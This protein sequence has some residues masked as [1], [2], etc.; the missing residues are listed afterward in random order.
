[1]KSSQIPSKSQVEEQQKWKGQK[2]RLYIWPREERGDQHCDE[3]DDVEIDRRQIE[4]QLALAER[5]LATNTDKK[6]G[7]KKSRRSVR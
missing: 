7:K 1:M 5:L 4:R 6:G 3:R 2:K